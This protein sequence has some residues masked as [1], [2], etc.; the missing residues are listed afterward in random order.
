MPE[1]TFP[2]VKGMTDFS[3]TKA[4]PHSSVTKKAEESF[5]LTACSSL[6]L[7]LQL[8]QLALTDVLGHC[9]RAFMVQCS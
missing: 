2:V 6:F 7:H 5:V 1:A 4:V 8:Q 3:R 9:R